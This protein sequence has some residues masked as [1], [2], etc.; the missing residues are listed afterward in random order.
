MERYQKEK[1]ENA[2]RDI[3]EAVGEDIHREG[4]IETPARVAN[5][6]E[7][8]FSSVTKNKFEE[9]KVFSS[10]NE[11]DMVIVKDIGFYSMCEHHL[12]PFF[13]KVH[14]A[15]IPAGKKVSGLSKLARMVDFC[16]KRPN[17]QENMTIQIAELLKEEV[18]PAGIAVSIEAE[19]L[20]MAMRGIKASGSTTKT[21]HYEGYF[22]NDPLLR[23]EF[24]EALR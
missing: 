3:L 9:N 2:V 22:K 11:E 19:H 17:V 15:Y 24:L 23:Q 12:L 5:M 14:I 1:I 10:L 18:R 8:I 4:L 6:Y 7:E 20:C 21:F 13:G 16:A